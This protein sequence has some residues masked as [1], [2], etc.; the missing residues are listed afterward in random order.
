MSVKH[1]Q[2]TSCG[3]AYI[4]LLGDTDQSTFG[5]H[6]PYQVMFGPQMC[7][8]RWETL[9][10]FTHPLNH[11][12]LY[13]K[14]QMPIMPD[15]GTH[16]YTLVVKPDNTFEVLIDLVPVKSGTL[17]DDWDFP[18]SRLLKAT[19]L[20]GSPVNESSEVAANT[21][22]LYVRC[23]NCTHIGL[24]FWHNSAGTPFD[25]IIVTDS[26]EEAKAYAQETFLKKQE[27]EKKYDVMSRGKILI[28]SGAR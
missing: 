25:D 14:D 16:L 28:S 4:K 5:G 17:A 24:E 21:E 22:E 27:T 10:A 7:R 20:D 12:I 26:L 11:E 9:V 3:G 2:T 6:T 8:I 15:Y 19:N 13:I 23:I 18:S 1:E